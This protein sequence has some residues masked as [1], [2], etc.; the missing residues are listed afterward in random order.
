M[1]VQELL[2]ELN[3]LNPE[4]DVIINNKC[5]I[6]SINVIYEEGIGISYISL[7]NNEEGNSDND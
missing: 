5:T 4:V 7:N 1:T 6:K 3:R 2:E